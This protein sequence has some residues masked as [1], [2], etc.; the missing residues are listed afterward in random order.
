M[1]EDK[2]TFLQGKMNKDIDARLLPNGEYRSAQNI[3][4][5]TSDEKDVGAIT[6]LKGN[7][8]IINGSSTFISDFFVNDLSY[9]SG[10]ETI[11]CFFDE[12]NNRIFYFVTN[13]TCINVHRQGLVG[14][15]D[16][17]TMAADSGLDDLHCAIYVHSGAGTPS[18]SIV[19][20]VDGLFLNFS[21]N[22]LITGVNL[23]DNLLFFTDNLNQPRKINIEKAL[24][25]SNFY[26][27]ED[28]IS[29]AKFAP[30][31]PPLLLNYDTT[32]F[33]SN[34]PSVTEPTASMQD[35]SQNTFS[36][37]YLRE[38]FVRFSYRFKYNDGEYSTIA[39]FTQICF[40]PKTTSY[41]ITNAQ[42]I[43]KTGSVYYQ[44]DN[45]DGDGMV[46][47]VT[48]VN[49]NIILP[50][51][52]PKK[53]F[54]ISTVEILYK[55]SDNNLVRS[56]EEI[57]I[58]DSNITDGVLQYLYKSTL[59]YKTL[60]KGQLVRVY[61]NV[62]LAAL[63]QE[64]VGNRIV[65]GNFVQD[66]ALPAKRNK[67]AG[68]DFSVGLSAKYDTTNDLGNADFNNYY[69]HKEYPFHSVKQRRSYEIGV[70]LSDKF[71]RQSPVL[72][73]NTSSSSV[74]VQA[75]PA[76]FHSS[77]WS[78]TENFI[79]DASP[80]NQDYCGDALTITFNS[81]IPN[82]Y[83]KRTLIPINQGA[84]SVYQ[85]QLFKANFGTEV[86]LTDGSPQST[87]T[88]VM[89]NNLYFYDEFSSAQGV[90]G[91]YFYTSSTLIETSIVTGYSALYL[92]TGSIDLTSNS[93]VINKF[94]LNPDTGEILSHEYVSQSFGFIDNVVLINQPV[95]VANQGEEFFIGGTQDVTPDQTVFNHPQLGEVFKL[96]ITNFTQT[97][98]FSVG[99]YLKGQTKDF[100]EIL[101]ILIENGNIVLFCEDKPSLEY[102]NS[103]VDN[104]NFNKYKIVPHGWY[105]YRVVV[106]QLEQDY[107]NVYV[108]S[109]I[110]IDKDDESHKSYIPIVADN[111]N[112][113]TRDIEFSNIQET[114]LS[115]SKA[116]IYPKILPLTS[117]TTISGVSVSSSRSIQSDKDLIDVISIGTAKEQ[118]LKDKNNNVLSFIYETNKNPLIAQIP[119]GNSSLNIGEDITSGFAGIE[120]DFAGA[121]TL[122]QNNTVLTVDSTASTVF[123]GATNSVNIGD[124]MFGR[125][126]DLVKILSISSTPVVIKCDG[127]ISNDYV[128]SQAM[129]DNKFFRNNYGFQNR[130]SVFETK[131]FESVLDIYYETSTAGYVHELNE[132]VLVISDIPEEGVTFI[133]TDDFSEDTIF[134]DE[135][136]N[137]QNVFAG[138][139]NIL[140]ENGNNVTFG[141]E[142]GQISSGGLEILEQKNVFFSDNTIPFD[143]FSEVEVFNPPGVFGFE[144]FE[145]Q[146]TSSFRLK[147]SQSQGSGNGNFLYSPILGG[148]TN[149]GSVFPEGS[150]PFKYIF[151]IRITLNGD[152]NNIPDEVFIINNVELTLKNTAPIITSSPD[153]VAEQ[154][155]EDP[156]FTPIHT[157]TATNGSADVT[158]NQE[159]L[160]FRSK[161]MVSPYVP[162][163]LSTP[164]S[165]NTLLLDG[166]QVLYDLEGEPIEQLY[167]NPETGDIYLTPFFNQ[168][169]F[170]KT[171]EIRVSD[172]NDFIDDID[173]SS[174]GGLFSDQ[175][176]TLTVSDGL[177]VLNSPQSVA[178]ETD[179]IQGVDIFA[180][181]NERVVLE[182]GAFWTGLPT[183]NQLESMPQIATINS[184]TPP[185][186]LAYG[187]FGIFLASEVRKHRYPTNFVHKIYALRVINNE[188]RVVLYKKI[189][190]QTTV[191]EN[192]SGANINIAAIYQKWY[193]NHHLYVDNGYIF[194]L[195][196]SGYFAQGG[197][198]NQF[199]GQSEFDID[200]VPTIGSGAGVNYSHPNRA[201]QSILQTTE[202][203]PDLPGEHPTL[204]S[205]DGTGGSY[206]Y[207]TTDSFNHNGSISKMVDRSG[208]NSFNSNKPYYLMKCHDELEL[209]GINY[210]IL[211]EFYIHPYGYT[212]GSSK[213]YMGRVFLC[214]KPE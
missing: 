83:S 146:N 179:L 189:I 81:E 97:D 147:P 130:L 91:D 175:T 123:T 59:P 19:K 180:T 170:I 90:V 114:G 135:F 166:D 37:D 47:S 129:A 16:G 171:F 20:L 122:S 121:G 24:Q 112:K 82:A 31:M 15:S 138:D 151:K 134:Y 202:W 181:A 56:V 116:Q 208:L 113:I 76:N 66:R 7:T 103:G 13:Y 200:G 89:I 21:K 111:I 67:V 213:W 174:V 32:T 131:P 203:D 144:V 105:S 29:V 34:T 96:T 54:E 156:T 35:S 141:D 26:N 133:N 210:S 1:A 62:P 153:V 18:S 126:K 77:S 95:L 132:A 41:S 49:L 2:K 143:Q 207:Y 94:N 161:L 172:A 60:P 28:K 193:F 148:P 64:V 80:G 61:D 50:S 57:I 74:E 104:Y 17:P 177:I 107:H 45:G 98:L 6:N 9:F 136:G 22:K 46:N 145:D 14:D 69:L 149:I 101:G 88:G 204:G 33:N 159:G 206:K 40:I 52:T 115:T 176:I 182:T 39:P 185:N 183:S 100:V 110:T 118:D 186:G 201:D 84:T 190:D 173:N 168:E 109:V 164:G 211:Y 99:D 92:N 78:S 127:E 160:R 167:I 187:D 162:V 58:E 68:L 87:A 194:S 12:K 158:R 27:S 30:F 157:V 71:G 10:L 63:A 53:D 102:S 3:Q 196:S 140:D 48:A 214:R 106:K 169:S 51:H 150:G 128:D 38:K 25:D 36:E 184:L 55:E 44:D 5:T 119:Y 70:V 23:L 197:Y 75:K 43:F 124:Y 11:G 65:Y 152:G 165:S 79:H 93:Y 142:L 125:N 4:I 199:N 192:Y 72:T 120:F 8:K 73:S 195:R 205:P 117:A 154:D 137:F 198:S 86:L 212:T 188:P 191:G 85:F 163:A 155:S 108:P 178:V 209:N 139:F 42:K